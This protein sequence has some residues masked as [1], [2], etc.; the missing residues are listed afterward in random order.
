[1]EEV[2]PSASRL[3]DSEAEEALVEACCDVWCIREFITSQ[4]GTMSSKY[5][6]QQTQR[7]AVRI[8]ASYILVCTHILTCVKFRIGL[9]PHVIYNPYDS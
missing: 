8:K 9:Y 3:F 6:R 5:T 7:E 2:S 4:S 1:M